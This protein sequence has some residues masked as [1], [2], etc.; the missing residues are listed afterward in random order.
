[1]SELGAAPTDVERSCICPCGR[2]LGIG[3]CD[4]ALVVRVGLNWLLHSRKS[5]IST[6][7]SSNS[8]D[9]HHKPCHL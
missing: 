2:S 7:R 8:E 1:M 4:V 3:Q 5:L 9:G 6:N